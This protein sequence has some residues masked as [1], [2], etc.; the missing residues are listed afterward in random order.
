MSGLEFFVGAVGGLIFGSIVTAISLW[1]GHHPWVI[2]LRLPAGL[3]RKLERSRANYQRTLSDEI[4][5]RLERSYEDKSS[6]GQG[7]TS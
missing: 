5:V 1:D 2:V 7:G 4:L 6:P 3:R